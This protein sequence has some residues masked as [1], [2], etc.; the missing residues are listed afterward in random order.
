M[1]RGLVAIGV[2]ALLTASAGGESLMYVLKPRPALGRIDVQVSWQTQGRGQSGLCV[3][4][5]WGAL[6]DVAALIRDF[7]VEG[8]RSVRRD[9]ACWIVSHP[10]NA[11]FTASYSVDCRREPATWDSTHLPVV[12]ADFYFAVGATFLLVPS[13]GGGQPDRYDVVVRWELPRNWRGACSWGVGQSVGD[14][15]QSG[16]LRHAAYLAGPLETKSARE[17]GAD[18]TVAMVGRYGF[19]AGELADVVHK[20]AADQATFMRDPALPPQVVTLVPVVS[21]AKDGAARL[22][23]QGLHHGLALWLAPE[24]AMT[25][26]LEH[27]IAHE[28]FHHWIG[29]VLK[30]A[31]PEEAV[32]WF[33]EG[34]TDYYALRRLWESGRWTDATMARWLN[35]HLKAYAE[36]PARNAPNVDV[37]ARART[38]IATFGEVPYQR[39]LLLGLRWHKTARERGVEGGLDALIR[40]LVQRARTEGLR[41]SGAAIRDAGT[42]VLGAWFT[43]E[44]ERFAVRGETV[45]L[46]EDAL[47]PALRFLTDDDGGRFE[48]AESP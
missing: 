15:L 28:L 37:Q 22:F 5:R 9:G 39:G 42:R 20:I 10:K 44:F 7:R 19:D 4:D 2:L 13:I 33:V 46:P 30:P 34:L 32:M 14:Q 43:P 18:I 25:E 16:E 3:A 47:A 11:A 35:R 48:P 12:T 26:G 21:S 27:V 23:G 38:E 8:A 24:S 41:L 31:E 45:A 17:G 40:H 29:G 1:R 6:R 36:N